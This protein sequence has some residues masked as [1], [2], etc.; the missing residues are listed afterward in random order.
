[1]PPPPRA[2]APWVPPAIEQV[3]VALLEKQ[4]E[5][6]I[7]SCAALIAALDE[8]ARVS[9]LP[10]ASV[11]HLPAGGGPAG[12]APPSRA[13]SFPSSHPTTTLG[14]AAGAST[15]PA[16]QRSRG[17]WLG[18]AAVVVVGGAV[19]AVM[20]LGGQPSGGPKPPPQGP[21][22]GGVAIAVPSDA[23]PIAMVTPDAAS[24]DA[25]F[26]PDETA[27]QDERRDA[28]PP[29]TAGETPCD[30]IVLDRLMSRAAALH[31]DRR[32]DAALALVKKVLA[33]K[34]SARSYQFA[35]TYAC[36]ARNFESAKLYL[37]KLPSSYDRSQIERQCEREQQAPPPPPPTREAEIAAKL[38]EEGKNLLYEDQVDAAIKKFQEAVA[39]VPEAKYFVNLCTALLQA[40]RLDQALS[41]CNAVELNNPTSDQRRKAAL[42]IA[43]IRAEAKKQ[44]LELHDTAP[45]DRAPTPTSSISQAELATRWNEEGKALLYTDHFD[46][47]IK[48][49]QDAVSRVPEPK[50]FVNL[51]VALIQAGRLADALTACMAVE[52][53]NP[54]DD[55]RRKATELIA[56]IK[57][58]A[59]KRGI[60]LQ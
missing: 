38:N 45:N 22:D 41:T 25:M 30:K 56:R 26:T 20:A 16:N 11:P 48:K 60:E 39:R 58:E 21:T 3:I 36:A 10:A 49:F 52:L 6:R 37:A 27:Q 34:P 23:A 47:A 1:M 4:P 33:C 12:T 2:I 14:S 59:T 24:A 51:C 57:A 18:V 29:R 32:S 7:P 15:Q 43:K 50:Y 31:V 13:G 19:T 28:P 5:R 42:L 17:V 8:A 54:T 35:A 9:G 40:G 44:N 55:Q 46:A 53:N